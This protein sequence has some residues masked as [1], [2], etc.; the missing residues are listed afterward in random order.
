MAILKFAAKFFISYRRAADIL[1]DFLLSLIS[2]ISD[3]RK[4]SATT[5]WHV[6]NFFTD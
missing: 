1:L 2:D 5:I 3:Q 4:I 6:I